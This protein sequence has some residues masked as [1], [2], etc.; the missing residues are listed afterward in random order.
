MEAD[1]AR[2]LRDTGELPLSGKT[3]EGAIRAYQ[4]A[5]DGLGYTDTHPKYASMLAIYGLILRD[6]N[7]LDLAK[8][9]LENALKIQER[10]LSQQNLMR[11][12]TLCN[13]GTVLHRMKQRPLAM[14]QL[15][16][17]LTM[18]KTLTSHHPMVATVSTA[19]GRLLI[20]LGE[21]Q[22]ALLSI[23]DALKMRTEICGA[24]HPSIAY[25]HLLL[26]EL[27]QTSVDHH[28]EQA[29]YVFE[30]L[31]ERER[32]HGVDDNEHLPITE[33]WLACAEK[34]RKQIYQ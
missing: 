11:V 29:A 2:V 7:E 20:D 32:G 34:I 27:D 18:L 22:S 15:N 5:K 21:R 8:T 1:I 28:F 31:V 17:S 24:V 12:E 3:M 30:A 6:S 14:A 10:V 19:F 26:A 25:Y 4:E 16:Q 33:E 13:L 9:Y 23:K